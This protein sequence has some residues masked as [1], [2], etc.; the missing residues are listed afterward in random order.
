MR[1]VFT[2]K[3]TEDLKSKYKC[4]SDYHLGQTLSRL[5]VRREIV[6]IKISPLAMLASGL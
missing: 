5:G 4:G 1:A 2:I 6:T 3:S